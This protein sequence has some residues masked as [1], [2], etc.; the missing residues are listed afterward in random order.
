[1]AVSIMDYGETFKRQRR[2]LQQNFRKQSLSNYHHIQTQEVHRL[3]NDLLVDPDNHAAHLKRLSGGIIMRIAYGH[4]VLSRD[5]HFIGIAEKGVLTI[6]AV[7]AIGAHIVDF[8]PWLRHIPDWM[9]GAG[10]KR[11]PPGTRED[12]YNFL[13][14]PFEQ[15]K[16]QMASGTATQC[17]TTTLMEETRGDDE[18]GVRSTAAIIYAGDLTSLK[19]QTL[20]AINTAILVLA[21]NPV[22]QARAQAEMDVVVGSDRLPTFSDRER[23]PYMQCIIS[24]TFRWGATTPVGVPHRLCEDDYYRGYYLP[25]D[26][27]IIANAWGMLHDPRVYPDP[28]RFNPDRFLEG[29]GRTPQPDPRGPAF[30]FGRRQAHT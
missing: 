2:Y 19:T 7:G 24:E 27:M 11:L 3:L 21:A 28:E 22:I 6:E 29:E 8:V 16:A 1:W 12:L 14:L 5:D 10:F 25:K 23:M 18:E 9:P 17:Y 30:G 26:S 13:H 20:S 15:V 4:Q